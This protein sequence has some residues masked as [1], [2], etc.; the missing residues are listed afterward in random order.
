MRVTD[1]THQSPAFTATGIPFIVIA[2][3][4]SG[5]I[6]W[7]SVT[8]WVSLETY[9]ENTARCVPALGDVLYTA[10]GSYGV[11]L[12]VDVDKPFMFQRHIAHIKPLAQLIRPELLAAILNAPQ[13]KAR[14]DEVARGVAQKTV[15]LGELCRFPIPLAP[16][17]EQRAAVER[18][19]ELLRTLRG[20]QHRL[21][22]SR[23][24]LTQLDQA[25]LAKAFRGELVPQDPND[26]P[27]QT[28]LAQPKLEGRPKAK[29][30]G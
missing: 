25:M 27:A 19:H 7:P 12:T 6:D 24:A 8:K 23:G 21:D 11:A 22:D 9:R 29:A 30:R 5:A 1:G 10:V 2:N 3:V 17:D 16:F 14:A 13:S 15:T 18:L 20:R 28:T 4:I 26:E